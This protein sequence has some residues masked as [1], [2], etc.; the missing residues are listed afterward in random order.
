MEKFIGEATS[1]LKS[2]N[3]NLAFDD[4]V[5]ALQ[6]FSAAIKDTTE[7]KLKTTTKDN[8]Q[9]VINQSKNDSGK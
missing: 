1:S 2:A 6:K 3:I 9:Q 7:R 8:T 4:S 5:K